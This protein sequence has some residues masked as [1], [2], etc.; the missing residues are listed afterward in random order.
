M[1]EPL[2]MSWHHLPTQSREQEEMRPACTPGDRL[3]FVTAPNIRLLQ[4]TQDET[5]Y[6]KLAQIWVYYNKVAARGART[7]DRNEPRKR[8]TE[9]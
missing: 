1:Q 3:P 6:C 8:R 9:I 4:K 7:M 5:V 2:S